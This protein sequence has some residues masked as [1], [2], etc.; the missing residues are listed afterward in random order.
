MCLLIRH[1]F[2]YVCHL[3]NIKKYIHCIADYIFLFVE[4]IRAVPVYFSP[5]QYHDIHLW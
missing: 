1:I 2:V 4:V 3:S 5:K